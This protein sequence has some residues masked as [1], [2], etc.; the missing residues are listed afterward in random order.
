RPHHPGRRPPPPRRGAPPDPAAGPAAGTWTDAYTRSAEF[1]DL[2][3]RPAWEWCGPALQRALEP[4]AAL[5]GAALDLGAGSGAGLPWIARA[6]PG[7][8][9]TAVE[10]SPVL[11]AVLLARAGADADLRVRTTVVDAAFPDL[12]L[13]APLAALVVGNALGHFDDA[14]RARLWRAASAALVPGGRLVCDVSPLERA[15][16]VPEAVLGEAVVGRRRY[17]ARGRAQ[18]VGARRL[19]WSMT[20]RVEDAHDAHLLDRRGVEYDW[21][22]VGTARATREA[23]EHGL[24]PAARQDVPG[25]LVLTRPAP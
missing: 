13:P 9:I 10:P 21:H 11:R 18:P 17:C 12:A 7:H 15:A 2:F 3:L 16:A 25:M 6:L 19:R 20:Y 14:L 23:G 5:D 4:V 8:P 22:V 1:L 24:V